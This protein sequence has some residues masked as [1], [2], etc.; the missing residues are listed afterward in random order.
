M[1]KVLA[2]LAFVC[3][4]TWC[5]PYKISPEDLKVVVHEEVQKL[6]ESEEA[7]EKI[8]ALVNDTF[9]VECDYGM[10]RQGHGHQNGLGQITKVGMGYIKS[11]LTEE[12][13][14]LLSD[15]GVDWKS[16][17]NTSIAENARANVICVYVYYR[18]R[19]KGKPFPAT[20]EERA[21]LWK[22]QYNTYKGSGTVS[23]FKRWHKK[24]FSEA[25]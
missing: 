2:F 4:V 10:W 15:T 12:E 24:W 3:G 1:R 23:R 17:T 20:L 21:K 6:P 18:G 8:E 13:K 9:A 14:K 16:M 11:I 7:K 19:L 25:G 22:V 5:Y